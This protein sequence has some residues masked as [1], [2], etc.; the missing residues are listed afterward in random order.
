MQFHSDKQHLDSKTDIDFKPN[1]PFLF[2]KIGIPKNLS[3]DIAALHPLMEFSSPSQDVPV[4]PRRTPPSLSMRRSES[5]IYTLP[6]SLK[7]RTVSPSVYTNS[8]TV[9]SISKLSSSSP[10]S[11]FS[12]KPHLNRV[13]S[14]SVKN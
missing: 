9:S 12:E 14:L 5:S 10:L 1:S 2:Y 8:S 13:H 4:S 3:L 6:T 11:S 7:N